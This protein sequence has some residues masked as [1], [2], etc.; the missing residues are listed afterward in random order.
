MVITSGFCR[1]G[2]PSSKTKKN[3]EKRDYYLN[4]ARELK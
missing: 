4:L 1:S 2:R 3:R